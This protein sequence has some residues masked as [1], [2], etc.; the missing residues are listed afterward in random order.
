MSATVQEKQCYNR[1][2]GNKYNPDEN[3]KDSCIFHPGAPFFH[4]AYKGWSCCNKKTVDFTEFLNTKGCTRGFHSDVKPAEPEKPAKESSPGPEPQIFSPQAPNRKL[5]PP[6]PRP[7][8]DTPMIQLPCTVVPSLSAALKQRAARAADSGG[9][10]GTA[11][12]ALVQPDTG[13]KNGGCDQTYATHSADCVHHPG[14]PIFHE[15]MKYWSCCQ[16]KT[17]DFSAF[18]AQQ[19]CSTG[20]HLWVKKKEADQR[21]T[22]CRYDWHQTGSHVIV[23]VYA[24]LARPERCRIEASP[25]RLR[26]LIVFGENEEVFEVDLE[27]KGLVEPEASSVQLMSSKVEIKLKKGEALSWS[28]LALPPRQREEKKEEVVMMKTVTERVDAVDL[29]DL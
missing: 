22:A 11:D 13:C 3:K 17:S 9:D 16:R 8:L 18:L 12:T 21:R 29:S 27:L 15:G 1:G 2:C 28:Q 6:A 26:P 5:E 14:V 7:P 20:D 25:I 19:G 4:D 23:A 10:P 24:K